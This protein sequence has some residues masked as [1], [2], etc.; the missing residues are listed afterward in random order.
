MGSALIRGMIA[1]G[2]TSGDHI[3]ISS[4]HPE[5]AQK[6]AETLGTKAATSNAEALV[7]ADV[8]FLCVK[9]NQ[10]LEVLAEVATELQEKLLISIVAGVHSADLL[11]AA[12]GGVRVIRTMPNTA[13]RLRKGLTA[14]APHPSALPDDLELALRIFSSVGTALEVQERDLDAVTAVSGSGPAFALLMLE[15][16]A[17]G[18]IE[19]GLDPTIAQACA[20]AALGAAAALVTE[21]GETPLALRQEITSPN[22]TTAAGLGVLTDKDFPNIVRDAVSAARHRSIELSM[23]A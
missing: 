8:V 16:L 6:A 11:Q 1:S 12:G 18:G 13:V 20:A 7:G 23:K 3:T 10:S 9:P 14:V 21:T 17:Q 22:G 15:S 19:G 2:L 5:S 4:K